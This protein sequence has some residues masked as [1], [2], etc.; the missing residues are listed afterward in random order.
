MQSH[1]PLFIKN[2]FPAIFSAH[3]EI[4]CKTQKHIYIGSG[5]RESDLK[6]VLAHRVYG[7]VCEILRKTQ[8]HIC[9]GNGAR[10]SDL[11]KVLAHRVYGV[12]CVKCMYLR[13]SVR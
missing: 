5:A 7:V 2:H 6:K 11:K 13:N 9:L 8:K 4:L 12:V 1:P 10:E 3:L